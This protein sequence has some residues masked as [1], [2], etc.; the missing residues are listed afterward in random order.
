MLPGVINK[1]GFFFLSSPLLSSKLSDTVRFMLEGKCELQAKDKKVSFL[2]EAA[3]LIISDFIL[4]NL[5]LFQSRWEQRLL[6]LGWWTFRSVYFNWC[7][8]FSCRIKLSNLWEVFPVVINFSS[9]HWLEVMW[10]IRVTWP[11]LL[12]KGEGRHRCEEIWA[13]IG[14]W[15]I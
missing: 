10:S 14:Y 5:L 6:T 12:T 7:F 3:I 2:N 4:L 1:M 15:I 9:F 8:E 11:G 13:C